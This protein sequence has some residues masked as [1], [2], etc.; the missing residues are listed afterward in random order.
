MVGEIDVLDAQLE[1]F[2]QAQTGAVK[3]A[4]HQP[5]GSFQFAEQRAHFRFGKNNRQTYRPLCPHHSIQPRQFQ[6]QHLRIKE[7][8]RGQRLI[9]RRRGDVALGRKMAKERADLC[10]P[11]LARMPL[12]G[13]KDET[14]DPVHISLFRTRTIVLGANARAHL[15]EQPWL[16]RLRFENRLRFKMLTHFRLPITDTSTA[17][18]S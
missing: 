3:Q 8:Q 10:R 5:S 12:A 13:E 17:M 16:P 1:A 6:R 14:L 9:L 15:I 4:R 18:L 2:A 7:E 11:H